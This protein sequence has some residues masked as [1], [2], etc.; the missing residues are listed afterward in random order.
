MRQDNKIVNEERKTL[1]N[2]T[3]KDMNVLAE[4]VGYIS[5]PTYT[6]FNIKY[7]KDEKVKN[8]SSIIPD[9]RVRL[10]LSYL[11]FVPSIPNEPY[12]GI[13]IVNEHR[14]FVNYD[15]IYDQLNN[16]PM[17]IPFGVDIKGKLIQE[18]LC[19][20]PHIL[21]T[22]T[23]GSGKSIF[24]HSLLTTLI[25]RNTPNDVQFVLIDPKYVEMHPY[26]ELPHLF[27]PIINKGKEALEALYSLVQKMNDR[28]VLFEKEE[29]CSIKEYNETHKDKLPYIIVVIDEYMDLYESVNDVKGPLL[30][31]LQKARASGIHV[32]ISM[33]RIDIDALSKAMKDNF[34]TV[35]CFATATDTDSIFAIN[36]PSAEYLGGL[37]DMLLKSPTISRKDLLRLQA[38]YIK[39]TEVREVIGELKEK[40]KTVE[41]L[42]ANPA[43]IID[44][45]EAYEKV[46]NWVLEQE[47][48]SVSKIQREC[49]LGFNRANRVFE[50]L[51]KDGLVSPEMDK[52]KGLKVIK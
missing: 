49:S 35:V 2:K 26:K 5:G 8:L 33:Q 48:V 14:D 30:S 43:P 3:F 32:I 15:D 21:V 22:G 1:I 20:L 37:G 17:S 52:K 12:S 40:Y 36:D 13:E 25:K 31:L 41:P 7:K 10:G 47:Y 4:C 27:R 19:V 18:D 46:K 45:D 29:V 11:R 38:P 51:Q 44:N 39:S 9:L 42:S 24:L 23:T 6:R 16:N 34:P 28:Y 50:R